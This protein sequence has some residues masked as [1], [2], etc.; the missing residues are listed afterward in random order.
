MPKEDF[1]AMRYF[2]ETNREDILGRGEVRGG[3]WYSKSA[4]KE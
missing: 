3:I 4:V 1:E 2:Y